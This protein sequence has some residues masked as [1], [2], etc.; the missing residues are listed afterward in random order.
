MDFKKYYYMSKRPVKVSSLFF[1]LLVSVVGHAQTWTESAHVTITSR[2]GHSQYHL[3]FSQGIAVGGHFYDE[4][5]TIFEKNASG[6]WSPTVIHEVNPPDHWTPPNFGYS[7]AVYNGTVVVGSPGDDFGDGS[8]GSIW[9]GFDTGA[10]FVFEKDE[11]GN[12]VQKQKLL[13]ENTWYRTNY[14]FLGVSVAIHEKTIA[15]GANWSQYLQN[16]DQYN[17]G[18]VYV[19][20]QD[21]SGLWKKKQ[22]LKAP[23]KT[24]G[25]FFGYSISIY[26][27]TMI[28]GAYRN[29]T[30]TDGTDIVKD[31]GAAYIF[32]KDISGNWVFKQKITASVRSK[33]ATFGESVSVYDRT[34]VVGTHDDPFGISGGGSAYVF[35]KDNNGNWQQTQRLVASDLGYWEY[36]GGKVAVGADVIAIGAH[37]ENHDEVGQND[38]NSAGAIYLFT[39][40]GAGKWI[41]RQKICATDRAVNRGFGVS[42][43]VDGNNIAAMD[44]TNRNLYFFERSDLLD[45][46]IIFEELTEVAYNSQPFQ[47]SASTTSSLPIVFSTSDPMIAS[48]DGNTV[49]PKIPG[50]VTI[51]AHQPGNNIYAPAV[52]QRTLVVG[53]ASQHITFDEFPDKLVID[54]DFFV[55]ASSSTGMPITFE[56]SFPSIASIDQTGKVQALTVGETMITATQVGDAF[57][58]EAS[59]SR[60]LKVISV[61]GIDDQHFKENF[62]V[63]PNPTEGDLFIKIRKPIPQPILFSIYNQMGQRVCKGEIRDIINYIDLHHL[64]SGIFFLELGTEGSNSKTWIKVMTK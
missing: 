29:D 20:E 13:T 27:K 23:D 54:D 9:P 25:D 26:K 60:T 51:S 14:E 48:V 28:I 41:E 47:L 15:A 30:D 34:I 4:N 17:D 33:D 42:V 49:T 45:Q 50:V 46:T 12:W 53:K 18:S 21:A 2:I 63:Y 3:G 38:L 59:S 5:A 57:T 52:V 61:L 44:I 43:A 31:A 62:E 64:S 40:D 36:F 32:E 1:L 7:S 22:V 39:K 19:F 11:S 24:D 55:T 37:A 6:E 35:T 58:K 16:G 56:S 10:L 8:D